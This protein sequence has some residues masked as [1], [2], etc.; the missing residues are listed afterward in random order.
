M[1]AY[2]DDWV[3]NQ[4]QRGPNSRPQGAN[5]ILLDD[6]LGSFDNTKL[7]LWGGRIRRRR[8]DLPSVE[9]PYGVGDDRGRRT[10][11]VL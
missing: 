5:A 8:G 6:P 3:D 11:E 7:L 1:W 10:Y 2:L 9:D 4:D